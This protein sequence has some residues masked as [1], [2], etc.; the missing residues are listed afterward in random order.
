VYVSCDPATLAR[1]L[2][3]LSDAYRLEGLRCFDLFPQTSQ[4]EAVAVLAA[5]GSPA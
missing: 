5:R 3:A 1:D 4:V 2:R